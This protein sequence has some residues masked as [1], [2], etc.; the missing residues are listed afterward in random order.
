M[1][2]RVI[3]L[4]STGSIGCG[5][6]DVLSNLADEFE[7]VALA[8]GSGIDKLAAQAN[9]F[10]PSRV[11]IAD[12]AG[13]D[14]LTAALNY[15]ADVLAGDGA[16]TALIDG[17]PCECVVCG[18]VGACGL[19]ATL[20]AVESGRRV[21]LAN[22]EALVI[23]GSLLMP[24]AI[25]TGAT[26]IP[27][28]SEHSGVFQAL[29]AGR[30]IDVRRIYLTASGGP[31]RT[32]SVEAMKNA[33]LEDALRHPTWTMG[34]K[35]TIDSATMMN[36][37]LEI[38]E[39]KWLFSLE[40]EAIDVV[41]H[42]ESIIHALVEFVD[43]SMVAQLGTPDM[44]TPIQY[45]L[46]YPGRRRGPAPALNLR[47]LGGLTLEPPDPERFPALR[48]GHRVA[49]VGGTAGAVMNAANEAAV[50]LFQSGQIGFCDI[51]RY[52][53]RVLDEHEVVMT[54]TLDELMAADR[55]ARGAL[56]QCMACS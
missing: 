41:V 44:R 49:R 24:L 18:V 27:I 17:T 22:K 29:R 35:V 51:A 31:F 23:A 10:T 28:D 30:P 52:T 37:A 50:E 3:V 39:A 25:R 14:D 1:K 33:T 20:R 53:E 36:K 55:W 38:V 15:D 45:A 42:P 6:L 43:G 7:V 32:A 16:L 2:Q 48:L 21:A 46:T 13:A 34:Q 11:A 4:G 54:P 47:A 8:A 40:P 9:R 5:A 12:A 56:H 26:V 19:A